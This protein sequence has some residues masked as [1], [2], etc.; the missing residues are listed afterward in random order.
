MS[1]DKVDAVLIATRH[2]LHVDIAIEAL[3]SGKAVFL[4]K[5]MALNEEDLVR[6]VAVIEKT[7]LPFMVGFNRRFSVFAQ[8]AKKYTDKRVN[9]LII[10]YRMNAGYIPLDHW[11]HSEEG[12]GRI[13]G[14]GCHIFDL[15]NFFTGSEVE[16]VMVEKIKPL[17]G[18]VSSRDNT[19]IVI[20]YKDGS[21]CQLLYTSLGTSAYPKEYC[22]IFFDNKIITID[23]YRKIRGYDVKIKNLKTELCD[24]GYYEELLQFARFVRGQISCP[25]PLWQMI[26]A[27]KISFLSV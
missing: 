21:L 2:N 23:D 9:P 13:I 6:L 5:P 24:K 15:F 11:V 19:I 7:K 18:A 8:E 16:K 22:E 1:D 12:G 10:N 17:T 26:Q 27:T 25:I 4:E 3:H 14:E 20:K